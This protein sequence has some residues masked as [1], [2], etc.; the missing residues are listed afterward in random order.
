MLSQ[1]TA[2]FTR[3]LR[4]GIYVAAY[5]ALSV[6]PQR[7]GQRVLVL[8]ARLGVLA[9]LLYDF[10]Y[11]WLHRMGHEVAVLWAAHVVHHQSQDYNLSTALRQT[12]S[13]AL[14]GWVFYL[15]DGRAGR[16]AVGVRCTVALIDLLYQFWVHTEQVGRL[17]WFDRWFCSPSNH[18]VHH[19]VNDGYLDKNYGG[20]LVL[21]GPFVR[22]RSK[23]KT[24]PSPACTAPASRLTAGTPLWANLEGIR[25]PGARQLAHPATG[26]TNCACGSSR[27]AG[28]RPTW[29]RAAIPTCRLTVSKS[30]SCTS[31]P[32]SAG[33][34]WFAGVKFLAMLGGVA[35]LALAGRQLALA[36]RLHR[37]HGAERGDVEPGRPATGAPEPAGGALM[38]D[39][40]VL[41][42][43]SV[44]LGLDGMGTGCFKPLALL[45][46][47]ISGS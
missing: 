33:V 17:G 10:C 14:L 4:V 8:L 1:I 16:A 44:G 9:L 15:P 18:R 39:A 38:V 19:A 41:A 22:Q 11:Y 25:R 30:S 32:T 20:I 5:K 21:V 46:C 27:P 28:N 37:P 29:L 43:A 31:R 40:A 13:G 23:T 3:L 45:A 26:P 47:F 35:Q 6:L 7:R 36:G 24:L 12:S 34:Q 2:I 42:M